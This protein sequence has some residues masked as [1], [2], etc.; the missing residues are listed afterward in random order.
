VLP[1]A[2]PFALQGKR[3]G[4]RITLMGSIP[5]GAPGDQ[6]R[7]AAKAAFPQ[8]D[9]ID[10]LK[11]A[12]GAPQGFAASAGFGLTE[13]GKLSEGQLD[14]SDRALSLTGR[15]IDLPKFADVRA[16]LAALPAGATL[17]KGLGEG[18]IL[19]PLVRPY[20]IAVEKTEQAVTV[21][22]F[23]P[24]ERMRQTVLA[25][26]NALGKPVTDRLQIGDG[27]GANFIN[28]VDFGVGQLARLTTGQMSLTDS[29]MSIT[30]RAP[31]G[32]AFS[33]VRTR[34]ASLPSG[35]TLGKGLGEGDILPPLMR[36]YPLAVE[37]TEQGVTVTGFVPNEGARQTVLA[38]VNALGRPV[39]DRLQIAEGAGPN[40]L[41]HVN[42]GVSQLARLTTGQM[43]LT[44]SA[45][46]ITG[47]APSGEAF[48]ELRARLASLPA[49][50]TL[51]RGLQPNDITSPAIRP[52]LFSAVRGEREVTLTGFVPDAAT[53]TALVDYTRRFFEG[54]RVTDNLQV[55]PG[56][57]AGFAN[58]ARGGLQDLS[59]LMPGGSLVMSDASVTLRGL[60]PIDSAR[61][62]ALAAFRARVPASFGSVVE[63]NTAPLPPP[64]TVFSECNIL[65]EDLLSRARINF[66]TGSST[67]APES[68]GLLDRLIV[69]V[70]RCA[71]AKVEIS[72]HTDS[73]GSVESNMTLS[74]ARAKAVVDYLARA[75]VTGDQVEARGFGPDRP[76]ASNETP[77]GR[78]RNRRIEFRVQ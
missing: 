27:A 67:I 26:V 61:D 48:D 51:A 29:A 62:A 56:A 38:A 21:S 12:R 24:N 49:G 2:K 44:D 33:D 54:D 19:P 32:A 64:I 23:V 4:N 8:A 65:F 58:V 1:E 70:R 3:E 40:F 35:M 36:P 52:Y 6:I 63:I 78:A 75:G 31:T 74:E 34:L 73:V 53:R 11:V 37:K 77:E 68:F 39:T 25:A 14:L 60:A 76:V 9:I 13:L 5:Y 72:G 43:S 7:A 47:R 66:D 15:A 55:G 28:H 59:R 69:V 71:G 30:G 46:S 17:G 50:M 16:K 22:G 42:F 18:D 45:M 41:S 10:Q 20:P 57:P